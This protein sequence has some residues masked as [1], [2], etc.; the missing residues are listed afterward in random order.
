MITKHQAIK[1]GWISETSRKAANDLILMAEDRKRRPETMI[2]PMEDDE[3]ILRDQA[4]RE[5]RARPKE[6]IAALKQYDYQDPTDWRK[7]PRLITV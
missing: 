3:T 4:E 6:N 1:Q 5:C 7:L 2:I